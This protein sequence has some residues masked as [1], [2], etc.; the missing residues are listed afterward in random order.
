MPG[1]RFSTSSGSI[2][3]PG[4]EFSM[5][6]EILGTGE[7]FTIGTKASGPFAVMA[8]P[9]GSHCNMECSYCYY[10]ET[11]GL[12]KDRYPFRMSDS[13]LE[14]YIRQYIEASPGPI[15]QFTWHGG[16]PTLAGLDFYRRTVELQK[17]Y[18]PEGWSCW[19]NLQTNG[20]LL[21][22]AWCSFLAEAHFDVGLSIDGTQWLHDAN[23]KDLSGG[24][25]YE[26]AVAAVRCLQTHGI[27]PDLLCTV[28]SA[29]ARE[30][31]AVYRALR[32]LNTG[33]IQF[34]PIVRRTADGQPTAESVTGEEYGYFLCAVF[35]EWVR[36]DLGRLD[37]QLFA[38]TGLVWSGGTA[39]LCWMAP[40][41][42]RVLI[43]E[44]DGGVYSCDHFV[45]PEHRIG[46]IETAHLSTL[47]DIPVQRC[48]G[49]SKK[50]SLPLQCRSCS[51]LTVCNGGC[52]KD[53]FAMAEDGEQGLNY[54]C[55]GLQKFFACAEQPLKKV[56]QLRKRG[57]APEAIMAELRAE[58]LARWKGVG[59]ND[60]CPCGSGRKAKLCCW[61]K[62]P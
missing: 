9:V 20:I 2:W 3:V 15:V 26:R 60:P 12:H 19:N 8:K 50:T 1:R 13:L 27:Q 62:R 5:Q 44:H 53:R 55:S 21:D 6:A 28:T 39:S 16:E 33:W 18:L 40:T 61:S 52:P 14:T 23:R 29:I 41:C 4:K 34:I 24:G 42:G 38:E 17:R 59:R 54:L 47:V 7:A 58:S 43:V 31:I 36:N 11:G 51:W 49:N 46:D 32:D 22:D 37:I 10:L 57:A 35:D 56:M 30:A 48:F 25:T 45:A